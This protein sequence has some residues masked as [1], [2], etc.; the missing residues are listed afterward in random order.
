MGNIMKMIWVSS[1]LMRRRII[2][3]MG[4]IMKMT[5]QQHLEAEEDDQWDAEE[6]EDDMEP[7]PLDEKEEEEE[8]DHWDGGE[9]DE[10]QSEPEPLEDEGADDLSSLT[11][12]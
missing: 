3:G 7:E 4:K 2:S 6:L 10:A 8:E 12:E 11:N 1:I 9:C 5:E